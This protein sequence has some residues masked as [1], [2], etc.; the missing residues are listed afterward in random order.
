[1]RRLKSRTHISKLVYSPDSRYLFSIGGTSTA[2]SVWD[3]QAGKVAQKIYIP[4]NEQLRR[5]VVTEIVFCLPN[6]LILGSWQY[7]QHL[8]IWDWPSEKNAPSVTFSTGETY[9][10]IQSFSNQ[11]IV[12][13]SHYLRRRTFWNPITN[14]HFPKFHANWG[15]NAPTDISSNG[16][17]IAWVIDRRVEIYDFINPSTF[18]IKAEPRA[19]LY[20]IDWANFLIQFHPSENLIAASHC[21]ARVFDAESGKPVSPQLTFSG[22][23]VGLAF[24]PDGSKLL[25]LTT[26]GILHIWNTS[27]YEEIATYDFGVKSAKCLAVSPDSLTCAIGG[28]FLEIVVVDLE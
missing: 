3:L 22:N 26:E 19:V 17:L 24:T 1:M 8:H 11:S 20:L 27:T 13:I 4:M 14:Q 16:K 2:A 5:E 23:A 21:P 15:G 25:L 6:K 9:L 18:Q 28:G 7:S 12:L 10:G